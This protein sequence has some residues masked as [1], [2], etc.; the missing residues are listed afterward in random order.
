MPK[1]PPAHAPSGLLRNRLLHVLVAVA[2]VG[3]VLLLKHVLS[4]PQVTNSRPRGETIVCFG[5]SLTAGTGAEPGESYP[6]QL[7]R[8]ISRPVINAGRPGDTT[9]S[10][11]ERLDADVLAHAPRIVCITLGGNDLKDGIDRAEAFANLEAIVQ[12]IQARGALV[13]IGGIDVPLFGRGYG[14]AYED[15][16]RRTGSVLVPDVYQGIWGRADLK[17]DPIHPN[18]AGY[19][20]MAEHFRR[21]LE[22]Y[23]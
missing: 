22:P 20:R 5:D 6:E 11:R 2:A 10:A 17:S 19:A 21:A 7:A 4:T 13:V 23:L 1:P 15:L 16:A 18:G 14:D 9:A 3:T 12:A 8:L